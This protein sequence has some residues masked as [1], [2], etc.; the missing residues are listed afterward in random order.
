MIDTSTA[1]IGAAAGSADP[2]NDHY[3]ARQERVAVQQQGRG[4]GIPGFLGGGASRR[5]PAGRWTRGLARLPGA[6]HLFRSLIAERRSPVNRGIFPRSPVSEC[7]EWRRCHGRIRWRQAPL[8]RYRAPRGRGTPPLRAG[9]SFRRGCGKAEGDPGGARSVL[10]SPATAARSARN[11]RRSVASPHSTARR[12]G[13]IH[14]LIGTARS[15]GA[16]ID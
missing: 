7:L 10:G 11:G 9:T 3:R 15:S 1:P 4:L 5:V 14:G 13:E 6:A 2:W 16:K 8:G 12:R